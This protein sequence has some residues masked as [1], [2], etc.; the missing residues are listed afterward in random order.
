MA[1]L[2]EHAIL[3]LDL[4]YIQLFFFGVNMYVQQPGLRNM[5]GNHESG[6]TSIQLLNE[7][8]SDVGWKIIVYNRNS[9]LYAFSKLLG[10][11]STDDL[12]KLK[13]LTIRILV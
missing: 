7:N 11:S 8:R 9:K 4:L 5:C 12:E 1:S 6:R 3:T 13:V 2:S 10:T